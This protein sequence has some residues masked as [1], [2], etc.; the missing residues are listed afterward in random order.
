LPLWIARI[1]SHASTVLVGFDNDENHAGDDGANYW[2]ETF[3]AA[4]RLAPLSH[5]ANQMLQ[6]K[7]PIRLWV[8]MGLNVATM[9]QQPLQEQQEN[10]QPGSG[11]TENVQSEAAPIYTPAEDEFFVNPTVS[12]PSKERIALFQSRPCASC[13][14]TAYSM[15]EDGRLVCPCYFVKLEANRRFQKGKVYA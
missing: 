3:S 2:L 4:M 14:S 7:K 15:R 10:Q 12:Q 8:E 9:P 6:D 1:F 13:G 11:R 5:D